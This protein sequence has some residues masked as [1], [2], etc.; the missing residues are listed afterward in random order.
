MQERPDRRR[1][2]LKPA[3]FHIDDIEDLERA[4]REV[5]DDVTI[6]H[7]NFDLQSAEELVEL[8]RRLGALSISELEI[9]GR[10]G[11]ERVLLTIGQRSTIDV[12]QSKLATRGLV[13]VIEVAFTKRVRSMPSLPYLVAAISFASIASV[14]SG[15]LAGY[16]VDE[17]LDNA[18]RALGGL[19][20][21]VLGVSAA[22]ESSGSEV[23][24]ARRELR[25]PFL[26]RYRDKLV[27]GA[28]TGV[29]G[30][31]LKVLVDQLLAK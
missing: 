19:I 5:L 31:L 2:P 13:Q 9:E 24:L 12:H 22:Y 18:G 6:T 15:A 20:A 26:T 25:P 17:A 16:L 30:Y 4:F 3:V 10:S 21:L 11:E 1:V 23:V 8:S 14:G 27:L 28:I 7:K 29:G